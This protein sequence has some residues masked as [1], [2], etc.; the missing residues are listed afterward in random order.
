VGMVGITGG[1]LTLFQDKLIPGDLFSQGAVHKS[2]PLLG[3]HI[4]DDSLLRLE[5]VAQSPRFKLVVTLLEDGLTREGSCGVN[6]S[7]GINLLGFQI[8]DHMVS[9]QLYVH[10]V[11]LCIVVEIHHLTVKGNDDRIL[12]HIV[13]GSFQDHLFRGVGRQ[14]IGCQRIRRQHQGLFRRKVTLKGISGRGGS[15]PV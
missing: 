10:V 7:L 8:Q 11:D 2:L 9:R 12:G 1:V 15:I 6:P 5:I 14:R 4:G 13:D 3:H